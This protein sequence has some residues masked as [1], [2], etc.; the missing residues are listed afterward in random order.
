MSTHTDIPEDRLEPKPPVLFRCPE[1][2]LEQDVQLCPKCSDPIW[3]KC[4]PE[5]DLHVRCL[6]PERMTPYLLLQDCQLTLLRVKKALS[7][8]RKTQ[9]H[10]IADNMDRVLSSRAIR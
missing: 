4:D 5:V 1:C 9:A 8:G 6:P 3:E 10:N 2:G 7:E